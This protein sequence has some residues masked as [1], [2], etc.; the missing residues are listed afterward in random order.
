MSPTLD[1]C[2]R[3]YFVEDQRVDGTQHVARLR[4][5]HQ[6]QRLW[7]RDED[8]GRRLQDL[9]TL[10]L[11]GVA[12]AHRNPQLRLEACEWTAKVAL[13][14]VVERLQR[15]NVEDP[16][17]LPRVA[18]QAVDRR[19]ER[20]QRLARPGRSLDQDVGARR[21]GRP[22]LGLWWRRPIECPFEPGPRRR[23]EDSERIHPPSVPRGYLL[24]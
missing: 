17:P 7:R 15:R 4:R 24:R 22:A 5:Q 6:V 11:R 3:M 21:D 1:A 9:A 19:E 13:D 14:V 2:N 18:G 12:R 23:R 8:V 16:Q 10:L 20:R